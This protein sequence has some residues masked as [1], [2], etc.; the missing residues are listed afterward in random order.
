MKIRKKN[1]IDVER[2]KLNRKEKKKPKQEA[3]MKKH[4]MKLQFVRPQTM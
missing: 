3:N 2:K 1:K 4:L